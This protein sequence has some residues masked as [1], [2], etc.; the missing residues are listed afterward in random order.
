MTHSRRLFL[1]AAAI[2][3]IA[4]VV[5]AGA[6]IYRGIEQVRAYGRELKTVHL[7]LHGLES[8]PPAGVS[9]SSWRK[10]ID[11]LAGAANNVFFSP[12][13]APLD[14]LVDFRSELEERFQNRKQAH[15]LEDLEWAWRRMGDASPKANEYIKRY[16]PDFDDIIQRAQSER[17]DSQNQRADRR[18]PPAQIGRNHD[19]TVAIRHLAS[20]C[21]RLC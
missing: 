20:C 15:S 18:R 3:L 8:K 11:H 14:Q 17:S 2:I 12:T 19:G 5:I 9:E 4:A 7:V 6:P 10:A 1:V 16:Q 21:R 13:S